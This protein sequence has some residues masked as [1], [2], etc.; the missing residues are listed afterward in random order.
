M[1]IRFTQFFPHM[2]IILTN[3]VFPCMVV[4]VAAQLGTTLCDSVD[5]ILPGFFVHGILQARILEWVAIFFSRGIFL[6]QGLNL[7]LYS[8]INVNVFTNSGSQSQA[9]QFFNMP[10]NSL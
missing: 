2:T 8:L 1:S 6:T 10:A 3:T 7:C 5:C 9:L 4:C